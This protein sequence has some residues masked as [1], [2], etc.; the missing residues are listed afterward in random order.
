MTAKTTQTLIRILLATLSLSAATATYAAQCPLIP[1]G[2]ATLEESERAALLSEF[3]FEALDKELARKH[4]KNLSSSGGDLL[5][6]RD[7]LGLQQLSLQEENV[8][9][10]WADQ[11]PKSFFAQLNAGL[12]YGNKA[13]G[14]RGEA[15][16][17]RVTGSQW[18]SVKQLSAK[19]QP[20]LQ[21]AMALDARSA[22][23]QTMLIGL[24][25]M[26]NQVGGRTAAQWLQA[27]DQADPKNLAARVNA[28]NY[29][30]PRWGGSLEGL[31]QMVSQA[32]KSLPSASAGYLQYNL[33]LA[34]AS[35]YEVV[36]KDKSKAQAL[37]KQAK[38]MCDNSEAARAGMVRTYQ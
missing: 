24:A 22:L 27:A 17:S 11:Q 23:P 2:N 9:R 21:K 5:T 35:H 18:N 15:P 33:V 29:L 32:V 36:D 16:A 1:D 8:M 25:A 13:F 28:L 14:A 7:L 30:S 31:D 3:K 4:K 34:K 26:E 12:Y 20:Y 38:D 10:M 19:A 37:Y 6:M